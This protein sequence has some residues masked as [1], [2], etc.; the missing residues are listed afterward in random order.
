[1]SGRAEEFTRLL[2]TALQA[3]AASLTPRFSSSSGITYSNTTQ[4]APTVTDFAV[5]PA[6][7]NAMRSARP[8]RGPPER[9]V[10]DGVTRE[11]ARVE[12]S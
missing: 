2:I 1:M 9:A 3:A 12:K 11:V 10:G 5:S 7:L 4:S 6:I 8:P